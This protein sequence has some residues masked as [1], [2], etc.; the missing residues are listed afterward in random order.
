MVELLFATDDSA[1]AAL[2]EPCSW[3]S[4]IRGIERYAAYHPANAHELREWADIL[5]GIRE[6][7]SER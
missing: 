1:T 3:G 6:L 4:I 5:H 2:D 7:R